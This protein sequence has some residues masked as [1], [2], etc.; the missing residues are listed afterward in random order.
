MFAKIFQPLRNRFIVLHICTAA[1]PSEPFTLEPPLE[2]IQKINDALSEHGVTP[3][4]FSM[5]N[6]VGPPSRP[7]PFLEALSAHCVS[8][9]INELQTYDPIEVKDMMF[10][11]PRIIRACDQLLV[12][13]LN[14]HVDLCEAEIREETRHLAHLGNLSDLLTRITSMEVELAQKKDI[15]GS[16]D[17]SEKHVGD[18]EIKYPITEVRKHLYVSGNEWGNER[19]SERSYGVTLYGA[20]GLCAHVDIFTD[21]RHMH[22]GV[23]QQLESR[24]AVLEALLVEL[25]EQLKK[26]EELVPHLERKVNMA[27]ERAMVLRLARERVRAENVLLKWF[28]DEL[29][30]RYAEVLDVM[31]KEDKESQLD[32]CVQNICNEYIKSVEKELKHKVEE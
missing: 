31:G 13:I 3:V 12:V 1:N 24:I 20:G 5:E 7:N 2:R 15:L 27:Q 21:K 11:K 28:T 14:K 30:N 10:S 6:K 22:A 29:V 32:E 25:R 26:A 17:T 4:H 23:I 9:L 8:R 19:R 18:S 16:L